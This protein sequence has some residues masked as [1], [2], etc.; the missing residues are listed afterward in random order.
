RH[1]QL[2][3]FTETVEV[4]AGR[5]G[6][7]GQLACLGDVKLPTRHGLV[8]GTAFFQEKAIAGEI[9]NV[10]ALHFIAGA[11]LEVIDHAEDVEQHDGQLIGAAQS[12]GVADG[13]G[14]EPAA[15]ARPAGHGAEL[16][17]GLANAFT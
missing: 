5:S 12:R 7:V 4:T 2:D 1:R 11:N 8:H 3:E 9:V 10:F 14:V 15:A 13:D 6:K 16:A 17:P